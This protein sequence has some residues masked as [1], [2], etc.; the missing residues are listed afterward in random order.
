MRELEAGLG[1]RTQVIGLF[2][3]HAPVDVQ[4]DLRMEH[5]DIAALIGVRERLVHAGERIGAEVLV[6]GGYSDVLQLGEHRVI[7]NKPGIN[8]RTLGELGRAAMQG[9]LRFVWI[10]QIVRSGLSLPITP[11]TRLQNGD[12]VTLVGAEPRWP[13]PHRSWARMCARPT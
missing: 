13:P 4:P 11:A 8:G 12:R 3:D 9:H 1:G 5:G 10:Q 2:R 7:I 6:P